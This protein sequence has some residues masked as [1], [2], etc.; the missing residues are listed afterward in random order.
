M[1]S[2]S[3]RFIF[4]ATRYDPDIRSGVETLGKGLVEAICR[5]GHRVTVVTSGDR[6]ECVRGADGMEILRFRA[7]FR[8]PGHLWMFASL[9]R[10]IHGRRV[11]QGKVLNPDGVICNAPQYVPW[12]RMYY[13]LCPVIFICHGH[14]AI[15]SRFQDGREPVISMSIWLMRLCGGFLGSLQERLA[16]LSADRII[17]LSPAMGEYLCHCERVPA[18]KIVVIPNGVNCRR[19]G[20][21]SEARDY[22]HKELRIAF[23]G[24]MSRVKNV[25][26]LIDALGRLDKEITWKCTLVGDG[27]EREGL[28]RMAYELGI[29]DRLVFAGW[30]SSP[31]SVY[32]WA[33]VFVLPSRWEG[34]SSA[35]LEAMASGL[36]C[37]GV[38]RDGR[39]FLADYRGMIEPGWNG[40]LVDG[41]NPTSLSSALRSLAGDHDLR[42]SMGR[43]SR[44]IA[45]RRFSWDVI[46]RQ[47]VELLVGRKNHSGDSGNSVTLL[48]S[49]RR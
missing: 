19:F 18:R 2:E 37:I 6:N 35:M 17:A 1:S 15:D 20:A 46:A 3:R 36:A 45:V 22:G 23:V 47:Y 10:W 13:R 14:H 31:S 12:A 39:E 11:C 28:E 42:A 32:Q 5:A 40:M 49:G 21:D 43:R 33:D 48:Q 9:L 44:D 38:R 4:V 27:P 30:S 29:R 24:R 16:N 8:S 25:G 41:N 26:Y 7:S 34:C